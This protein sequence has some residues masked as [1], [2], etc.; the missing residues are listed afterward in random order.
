MKSVESKL[1]RSLNRLIELS[2]I[3]TSEC[4]QL[5]RG[6]F[7]DTEYSKSHGDSVGSFERLDPHNN[8]FVNGDGGYF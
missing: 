1:I 2:N 8:V 7:I 4:Y 5:V 3:V 6:S